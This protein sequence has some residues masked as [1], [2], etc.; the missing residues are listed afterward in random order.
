MPGAPHIS[1]AFAH[2]RL[3]DLACAAPLIVVYGFACAGNAI[4]I[5]R[6]IPAAQDG[7]AQLAI[8]S[9]AL[10]MAYLGLQIG[11]C[12]FRQLPL[13]KS[14][15]AWPRLAAIAGANFSVLL[16][17]VPRVTLGATPAAISVALITLGTIA[18]ILV[19]AYLGRAFSVFPEARQLVSGGPYRYIRHPLYLAEMVATLGIVLQFRQPWAALIAAV[20]FGFQLFR[21]HFEETVLRRTFANYDEATSGIARLIPGLY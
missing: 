1:S 21:I 8:A 16:L 2:T 6:Q 14:E 19:L 13:A 10:A 5:A 9:D 3:Y 4:L 20:A 12:L 7:P 15:G 11:L 17:L 18:C